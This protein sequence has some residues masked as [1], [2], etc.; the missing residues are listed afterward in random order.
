[1]SESSLVAAFQTLYRV[2]K[3][4]VYPIAPPYTPLTEPGKWFVCVVR[5]FPNPE[6]MDFMPVGTALADR[7]V[8]DDTNQDELVE[9]MSKKIL[10]YFNGQQ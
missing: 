9:N 1:M 2:I 7:I 6:N 4:E 8:A 3:V 5:R 10:L